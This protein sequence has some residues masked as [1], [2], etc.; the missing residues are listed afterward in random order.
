MIIILLTSNLTCDTGRSVVINKTKFKKGDFSMKRLVL[1][2]VALVF[3][4]CTT[5]MAVE[6]VKVEKK[7]PA[8]I[9]S[10]NEADNSVKALKK[11]GKVEKARQEKLE[12]A[13]NKKSGKETTSSTQSTTSSTGST[14][15]STGKKKCT[16][17]TG[18]KGS[19]KDCAED[20]KGGK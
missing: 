4:L 14:S 9:K 8:E 20:Q 11:G 7:V 3:A 12:N 16:T 15:S 1:F 13:L 6:P 2:V 17:Y 10:T 5:V 19:D 18:Q